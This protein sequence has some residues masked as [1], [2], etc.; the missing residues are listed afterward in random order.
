LLAFDR[1]V[2]ETAEHFKADPIAVKELQQFARSAEWETK[3]GTAEAQ[4]K[5][6]PGRRV[7]M[8]KVQDRWYL[9]DR[10]K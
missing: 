4:V 7:F 9:E 6:V 10:Q 5:S 2:A 8:K 1:L 3:D